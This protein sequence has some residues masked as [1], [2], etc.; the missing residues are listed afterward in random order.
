LV[1]GRDQILSDDSGAS[2]ISDSYSTDTS[3]SV[4]QPLFGA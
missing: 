2:T 3:R 4:V 1:T